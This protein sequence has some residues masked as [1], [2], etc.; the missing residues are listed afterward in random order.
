MVNV[1]N[2]SQTRSVKITLDSID[3]KDIK[4][5][6]KIDPFIEPGKS[7]D[8]MTDHRGAIQLYVWYLDKL[9]WQGYIPLSEKIILVDPDRNIVLSDGHVFPNNIEHYDSVPQLATVGN[10][11]NWWLWLVV[12]LLFICILGLGFLYYKSH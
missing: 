6:S 9:I 12:F 5:P 2:M 11:F 3:N 4:R 8:Y 1:K 10:T 7:M